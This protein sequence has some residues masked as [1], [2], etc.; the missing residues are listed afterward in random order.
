MHQSV[1]EKVKCKLQSAERVGI[2]SDTWTSVATE[3]YMS[4]TAH[5]I[6]EE[7][8]L[9]SYVLQ[10]TEV[11]TDHRS[12]SLAE[13]LTAALEEWGLM[14]KDPA[15]VAANMVRAVEIMGLSHIGCFAHIINL[16]SQA[17]LKLPNIARLLG[18]VRHIRSSFIAVRQPPV[19]SK[20]SRHYC[21]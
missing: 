14:S 8:N 18:R 6:D 3:S 12:A 7:W 11:E 13:M 1:K 21:S 16:A 19:S 17:G 10:T 4:V 9:I 15:I 5:Y 2:T 20:K